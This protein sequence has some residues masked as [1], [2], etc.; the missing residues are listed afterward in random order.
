MKIRRSEAPSYMIFMVI[1]VGGMFLVL[2]GIL[3]AI[4]KLKPEKPYSPDL[5]N[6]TMVYFE[7]V[8]VEQHFS[9][10]FDSICTCKTPEGTS[11]WIIMKEEKYEEL[12][13]LLSQ[14]GSVIIHGKM[15]YA[16]DMSIK[17]LETIIK[18]EMIVYY[19]KA[20]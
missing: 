5:K 12:Q 2:F 15:R 17:H 20:S 7:A 11:I 1:L 13:N 18:S 14:G 10:N 9:A 19:F 8:E 6:G 16:D 4:D 3:P